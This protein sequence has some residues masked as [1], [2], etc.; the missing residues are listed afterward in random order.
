[1]LDAIRKMG[2]ELE[3]E[4]LG[5]IRGALPKMREYAYFNRYTKY[6]DDVANVIFK[7]LDKPKTSEG[8]L[9]VMITPLIVALA[10]LY[11][12]TNTSRFLVALMISYFAPIFGA[13][14]GTASLI[15]LIAG[16]KVSSR[17]RGNNNSAIAMVAASLAV[18]VGLTLSGTIAFKLGVALVIAALIGLTFFVAVRMSYHT[19]IGDMRILYFIVGATMIAAAAL[20]MYHFSMLNDWWTCIEV[21]DNSELREMCQRQRMEVLKARYIIPHTTSHY[22]TKEDTKVGWEV[23]DG[24]KWAGLAI[25]VAQLAV[26]VAMI[27]PVMSS[28]LG[29]LSRSIAVVMSYSKKKAPDIA[30]P[31]LFIGDIVHLVGSIELITPFVA[32]ICTIMYDWEHGMLQLGLTLA[33]YALSFAVYR[34]AIQ[35]QFERLGISSAMYIESLYG[36]DNPQVAGREPRLGAGNYIVSV[37]RVFLFIAGVSTFYTQLNLIVAVALSTILLMISLMG[38]MSVMMQLHGL[39]TLLVLAQFGFSF[40]TVAIA[41]VYYVF[42]TT[43][44]GRIRILGAGDDENHSLRDAALARQTMGAA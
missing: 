21:W 28:K 3:G 34:W 2:I 35:P 24:K 20:A 7:I 5:Q 44:R 16:G 18:A 37:V 40:P 32:V 1:M 31:D 19:D 17:V 33:A 11:S 30:V 36:K 27:M 41:A 4:T 43:G 10:A 8:T 39:Y 15:G 23:Q 9:M 14:L 22:A 38:Y 13:C 29:E 26:I 25:L 6:M 12:T 42:H